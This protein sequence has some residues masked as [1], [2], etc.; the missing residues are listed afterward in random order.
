MTHNDFNLISLLL[1]LYKILYIYFFCAHR[2]FV[3]L[4]WGVIYIIF[5]VD[6]FW[7]TRNF[8]VTKFEGKIDNF[9]S[10]PLQLDEFFLLLLLFGWLAV[11]VVVVGFGTRIYVLSADCFFY[12]YSG[13][14]PIPV[15]F[16][17]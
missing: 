13:I 4:F 14:L 3:S 12:F 11:V 8:R 5:F 16:I 6:C 15:L 17:C 2:T 1:V 7:E 9:I 10:T